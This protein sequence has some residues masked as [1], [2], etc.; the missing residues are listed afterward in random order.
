MCLT[1]LG[2]LAFAPEVFLIGAGFFTLVRPLTVDRRRVLGVIGRVGLGELRGVG[3]CVLSNNFALIVDAD[4][5]MVFAAFFLEDSMTGD[6]D[7]ARATLLSGGFR[8]GDVDLLLEDVLFPKDF[9]TGEA[10]LVRAILSA[11]GFFASDIDVFLVA[12][13][14]TAETELD[15][16]LPACSLG[17]LPAGEADRV[18]LTLLRSI[19]FDGD[20]ELL[21]PADFFGETFDDEANAVVVV[22]GEAGRVERVNFKGDRGPTDNDQLSSSSSGFNALRPRPAFCV[23]SREASRAAV[24]AEEASR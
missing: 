2:D 22:R 5:V 18:L 24:K 11:D 15:L 6:P 19:P 17:T 3:S 7:L 21:L 9:F 8:P 16:P 20:D 10:D 1:F 14:T 12:V 4:L 13:L 23:G